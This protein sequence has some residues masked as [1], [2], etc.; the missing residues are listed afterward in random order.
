MCSLS[1]LY[2]F[3]SSP[4]IPAEIKTITLNLWNNEILQLFL[5]NHS[6]AIFQTY[7]QKKRSKKN[8]KKSLP[9]IVWNISSPEQ[10]D[11][12]REQARWLRIEDHRT[13]QKL[14]I[15]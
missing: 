4:C 6:F 12:T 15:R 8:K 3:L 14:P 5:E 13:E 11:L 2:Y 9:S 7:D 1:L 10:S